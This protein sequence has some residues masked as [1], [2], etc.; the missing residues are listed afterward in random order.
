MASPL[1]M[2]PQFRCTD[3]GSARHGG[4]A[5]SSKPPES[6]VPEQASRMRASL[7]DSPLSK[8]VAGQQAPWVIKPHESKLP[9]ST[10]DSETHSSSIM[11][12][13]RRL[14]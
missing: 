5:S 9:D 2:G 13:L 10:V 6:E 11:Y 12:G 3:T 14:Y 8:P 1:V 7:P 4:E